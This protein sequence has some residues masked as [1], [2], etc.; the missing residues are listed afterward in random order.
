MRNEGREFLFVWQRPPLARRLFS[1]GGCHFPPARTYYLRRM[2]PKPDLFVGMP[3]DLQALRK[4]AQRR[5]RDAARR[6]W[7]E[8]HLKAA[9]GSSDRK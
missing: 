6:E 4:S 1:S 3:A 9:D 5:R 7:K 8:K 2:K